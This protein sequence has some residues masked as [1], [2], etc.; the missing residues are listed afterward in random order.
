MRIRYPFEFEVTP[1]E[2]NGGTQWL[3]LRLKNIIPA[4]ASN[5]DV[6]VY[7]LGTYGISFLGTE[8]AHIDELKPREEETGA[9]QVSANTTKT[10][11]ASVSSYKDGEFFWTESPKVTIKVR[12]DVAEL[13]SVF[14]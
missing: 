2:I 9:F 11:Y 12:K 13:E 14:A 4:T 5:L 8:G 3:T 6:R 7:S 10:L 1:K